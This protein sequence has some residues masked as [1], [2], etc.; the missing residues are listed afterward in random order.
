MDAKVQSES[1]MKLTYF[2]YSILQYCTV[3]YCNVRV[4]KVI[5]ITTTITTTSIAITR[6]HH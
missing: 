3:L 4:H 5:T 6:S 1:I 2:Y